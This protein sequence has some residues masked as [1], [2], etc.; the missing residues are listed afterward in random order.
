MTES[1]RSI[2]SVVIVGGGTAG[3]MTAAALGNALQHGCAITLVESEEIGTV[4]VGEAT[5]PPI[6]LFNQ[7]LGIDEHEFVRRTRGTFK[8]GIQFVDWARVGN[9]YFHPFGSYGRPFDIVPLHHYWCQAR[10]RQQASGLDDYCMAWA[11]AAAGR[12]APP[13]TDTRNVLSTYDYAYHFD[14]SL[15]AAYLREYAEQ[16]RVTRVEGRVARV[17]QNGLNGFVESVQLEDGRALAADLFIDCSGFRGL[18]IEGALK[19]GYQDWTHW[20]PCDRAWAVP[21]ESGEFTPYTRSTA[22]IAGWQWRI[23]LQHRTGN[24]HV[25]ASQ[26]MADD[27]ARELLLAN[28]DGKALAEPRLLRFVTGRRNLFW[29]KNVIAIGLSSGFMEPLESTSIH[30]I[31]AGIAKL[32]ALFPDRDFDAPGIDEYNRIAISEFERIR[33][34][35]ILHYHLTT[36]AD[37]ELWR[38][39]ASMSIPETLQKKIEHFRRSGRLLA[40]D[41]DL[42]GPPSWLAVHVGQFNL[43]ECPDALL[44]YRDVDAVAW[45]G[46]LREAMVAAAIQLPTHRQYIDRHCKAVA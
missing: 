10:E 8:V 1:D 16:R 37:G 15:Y 43:P 44:R 41:M 4:G 6:R 18:L 36:R 22:R 34:F 24:G 12:F 20:L 25:Y 33:D 11:L 27:A 46:K 2:R 9:R 21:C 31:Q 14:A 17:N 5:I 13:S 29:N 40:Y 26:F 7:T 3:W 42:F 38:Y 32:L 30:L 45:L 19:T 39:C 23:P 28:L 35:L